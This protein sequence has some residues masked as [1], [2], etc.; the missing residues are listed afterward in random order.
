MVIWIE[1][2]G[3]VSAFP[4]LTKKHQ[5]EAYEFDFSYYHVSGTWLHCQK[6]EVSVAVPLRLKK[7]FKL[8]VGENVRTVSSN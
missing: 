5:V 3:M 4:Y 7:V 6:I 2:I 8:K 1:M